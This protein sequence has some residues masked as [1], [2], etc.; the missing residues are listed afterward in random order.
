MNEAIAREI[1]KSELSNWRT[2]FYLELAK[3]IDRTQATEVTG[4]DKKIYQVEIQ[5]LWDSRRDGNIRVVG[6]ID[7]RGFRAFC[8]LSDSFI[9]SPDG[10]F[11]GE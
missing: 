2:K 11:V 5:I 7:D 1:L 3:L 10:K 4:P 6:A 9:V 8:P